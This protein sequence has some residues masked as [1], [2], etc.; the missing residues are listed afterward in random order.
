MQK[1]TTYL[2][3]AIQNLKVTQTFFLLSITLCLCCVLY[4]HQNVVQVDK[5]QVTLM[6]ENRKLGLW[7]EG[8]YTLAR[9]IQHGCTQQLIIIIFMV[10]IVKRCICSQLCSL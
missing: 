10:A 4:I 8:A 3:S 6:E 1:E 5:I 2:F 9:K 7:V